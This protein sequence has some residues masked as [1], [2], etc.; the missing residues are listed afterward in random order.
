MR[1][2]SRP[3]GI[4]AQINCMHITHKIK[5]LGCSKL[6]GQLMHTEVKSGHICSLSERKEKTTPFG[7]NLME[8]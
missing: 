5:Q 6:E 2:L 7:V 1:A 4:A 3:V 8:S